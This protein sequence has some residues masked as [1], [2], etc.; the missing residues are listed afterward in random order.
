MTQRDQYLLRDFIDH[1]GQ[2]GIQSERD[3]RPYPLDI[4]FR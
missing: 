1:R 4:H 3:R 2:R